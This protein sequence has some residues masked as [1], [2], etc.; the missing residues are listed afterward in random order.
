MAFDRESIDYMVI[1]GQA[2]LVHGE[3]RMTRDIDVVVSI[4]VDD[5]YRLTQA[6]GTIGVRPAVEDATEFVGQTMVLPCVIEGSALRLDCVLA[7]SPY[8]SVALSRAVSVEIDGV[9]V[10]FASVEDLVIHKM[11]AG[12]ARD[13]E[14]VQALLIKNPTTDQAE[15][16]Q[17]LREFGQALDRDL[18]AAFDRICEDQ[19]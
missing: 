11:I 1:G 7:G 18:L 8:E 5:L 9:P 19:G 4:P 13:H 6:L 15:I 12:R 16:R 10:R 14:D 3:P 2:V 17:W